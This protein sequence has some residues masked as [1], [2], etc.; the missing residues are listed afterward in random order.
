MLSPAD[1][2]L[3]IHFGWV[4]L[5][6]DV[7]N[8]I[9]ILDS[10]IP[11]GHITVRSRNVGHSYTV[12]R[13]LSSKEYHRAVYRGYARATVFG[14]FS[15]SNLNTYRAQRMGLTNPFA[16]AWELV[17]FS[18]VVDWFTTVGSW[19]SQWDETLGINLLNAGYSYKV[20]VDC[21]GV[22]ASYKPTTWEGPGWSCVW[23]ARSKAVYFTRNTGNPGVPL[24]MKP[25]ARLSLAR[26]ATA[27]ALLVQ[28][29]RR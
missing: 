15:V 29:L 21:D 23:T 17:P 24:G 19:I 2:W 4:P 9:A 16:V 13:T 10:P 26:G 22:R 1:L 27:I 7:Q 8:A 14:E 20:T 6:E 25:S 11:N 3:E 5:V 12:G 18:F 28:Q